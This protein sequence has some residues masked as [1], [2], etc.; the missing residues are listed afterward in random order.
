MGVGW[1]KFNLF[2]DQAPQQEYNS[3]QSVPIEV[4]RQLSTSPIVIKKEPMAAGIE[5]LLFSF[6]DT[7]LTS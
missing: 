3:P 6:E 5:P 2:L 7:M 4:C 1:V